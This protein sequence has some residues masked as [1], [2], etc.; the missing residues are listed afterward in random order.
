MR[1]LVAFLAGAALVTGLCTAPA[2]SQAYEAICGPLGVLHY[3]KEKS[4]GGYVL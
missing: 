1:K 4:Y 2:P 3:Q